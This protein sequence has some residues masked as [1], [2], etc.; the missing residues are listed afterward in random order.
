MGVSDPV[1]ALGRFDIAEDQT[2]TA[3]MAAVGYA[4]AGERLAAS[5]WGGHDDH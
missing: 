5:S 2:L 1:Q 3:C 4:T